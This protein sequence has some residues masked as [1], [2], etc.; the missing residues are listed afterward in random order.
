VLVA[1]LAAE[2]A[3][4]DDPE[5]LGAGIAEVTGGGA[6]CVS[7]AECRARLRRGE[8][9]ALDGLGGR[10]AIGDDGRPTQSVVTVREHAADG[11]LD[12]NRT[13]YRVVTSTAG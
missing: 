9:V 13:E 1:A 6:T 11:G 5:R 4:T 7:F 8:D 2:A 3:G 10:L 12:P